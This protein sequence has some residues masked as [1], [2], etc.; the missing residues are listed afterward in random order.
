MVQSRSMLDVSYAGSSLVGVPRG[1]VG[2]DDPG[3]W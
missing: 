1:H 2:V 3:S